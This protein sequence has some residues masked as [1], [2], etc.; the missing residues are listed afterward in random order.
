[1]GLFSLYYILLDLTLEPRDFYDVGGESLSRP[2]SVHFTK[3]HRRICFVLLSRKRVELEARGR[4]LT[5]VEN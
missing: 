1:M 3:P 2:P 4:I 5:N